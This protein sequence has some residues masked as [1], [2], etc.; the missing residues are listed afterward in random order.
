MNMIMTMTEKERERAKGGAQFFI[1][2]LDFFF[3]F[4]IFYLLIWLTTTI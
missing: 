4:F 2:R 3:I 1:C